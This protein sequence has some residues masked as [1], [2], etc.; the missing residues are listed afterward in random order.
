M[1]HI[2]EVP[3]AFLN[4]IL[5]LAFGNLMSSLNSTVETNFNTAET[6]RL[7]TT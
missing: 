4:N 6:V 2:N 7:Q 1:G 3:V 5:V